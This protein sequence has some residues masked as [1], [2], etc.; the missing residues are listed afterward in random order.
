MNILIIHTAFI[1]DIVLSTALV[2]KVKEKYKSVIDDVEFLY[3]NLKL[4]VKIIAEELRKQDIELNN[5]T[6]QYVTDALKNE[7]TNIA[8]EFIN[9]YIY[10]NENAVIEA[11]NN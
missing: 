8:Q 2:S 7:K 9:A 6:L 3:I 4:A 1:G 11:K 5:I 10:G